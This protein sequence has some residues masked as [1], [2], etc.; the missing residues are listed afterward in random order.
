[1][2]Q[3]KIITTGIHILQFLLISFINFCYCVLLIIATAYFNPATYHGKDGFNPGIVGMI[4]YVT[5]FLSL[6]VYCRIK[7]YKSYFWY[8]LINL[9]AGLIFFTIVAFSY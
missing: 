9:L 2:S 6:T 1:M 3:E 8:F 5:V 7:N 4:V